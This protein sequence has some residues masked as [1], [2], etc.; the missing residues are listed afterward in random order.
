MIRRPP[1]S[2]RVRSSAA[3]DVYKRQD[4]DRAIGQDRGWTQDR[5]APAGDATLPAIDLQ[6]APA[7]RF[8]GEP[9]AEG[10]RRLARRDVARGHEPIVVPA[11]HHA[12]LDL[13][14]AIGELDH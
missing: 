14:P 13:V 5:E 11:G 3:S 7:G 2:T 10:C 12:D 9:G 4:P 6:D 8:G 1:R